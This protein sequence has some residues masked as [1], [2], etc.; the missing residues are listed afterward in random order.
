M[1]TMHEL[2]MPELA[3]LRAAEHEAD[4]VAWRRARE[5]TEASR[6]GRTWSFAALLRLPQIRSGR[7]AKAV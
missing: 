3:E 4:A 6:T 7:A 5:A 1:N 2:L